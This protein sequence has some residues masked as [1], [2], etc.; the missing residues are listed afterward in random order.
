MGVL[1]LTDAYYPLWKGQLDGKPT[2][3]YPVNHLFRGLL[4]PA[5]EHDVVFKV[6]RPVFLIGIIISL[7]SLAFLIGIGFYGKKSSQ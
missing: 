4:L 7:L 6:D 3:V 2:R 1:V 5:G